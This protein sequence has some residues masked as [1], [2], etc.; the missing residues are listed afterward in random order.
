MAAY[1]PSLPSASQLDLSS[2]YLPDMPSL[3]QWK[4]PSGTL[5]NL[6]SLEKLV[7]SGSLP[8]L[9]SPDDSAFRCTLA[10]MPL[11]DQLLSSFGASYR[12]WN[13]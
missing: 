2:V 5:Q 1:L 12:R 13:R 3:D 4:L 11:L 8:N 10:S 6:Q 9:P 7:P